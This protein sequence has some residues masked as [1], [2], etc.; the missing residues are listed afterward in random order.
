MGE[1]ESSYNTTTRNNLGYNSASALQIRLETSQIIENVE[2]FLKGVKLIISQDEHGKIKS[3]NVKIGTAKANELGIQSILNWLQLI[4]NPQV[5]QGNFP[6]DSPSHSSM[7]EDYIYYVRIDLTTAIITNCYNWE[8]IDEDMD[9]I[10]DSIMNAIEPFMTRL[11]D[12]KERD[13]YES[14]I[15]HLE[16]NSVREGKGEG[17]KLFGGG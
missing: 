6:V 8:I 4:L 17:F 10:I 11:I 3:K 7:Y 12:N 2:L 15:K 13:S 5:V 1:L 16:N 14:T 9:L